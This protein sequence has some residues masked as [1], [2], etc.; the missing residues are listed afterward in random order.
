MEEGVFRNIN[1]LEAL[2]VELLQAQCCF[3]QGMI[4]HSDEDILKGLADMIGLCYL[5]ARRMGL[6]F[7]KVDRVLMQRLEEWRT[8]EKTDLE[9]WWG[10]LSMLQ[11]YLAPEE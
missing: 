7:A 2:K 1:V 9:T 5:L 8:T 6:D 10:D 3:Q 11:N 4:Q